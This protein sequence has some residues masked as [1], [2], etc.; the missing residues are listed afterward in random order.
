MK[1]QGLAA[2]STLFAVAAPLSA[3]VTASTPAPDEILLALRAGEAAVQNLTPSTAGSTV[4]IDVVLDGTA[5]TIELMPHSI[6]SAQFQLLVQGEDGAI[7]PAE[8]TVSSTYRGTILGVPDS[9]VGAS[10]LDAQVHALV[11]SGSTVFGIQPADELMDSAPHALHV[12][13][14]ADT[15]V[16]EEGNCISLEN[17]EPFI[18]TETTR[19]LAGGGFFDLAQHGCDADVQYFQDNGSS[20]AQTEDRVE[21]LVNNAQAIYEDDV[22]IQFEISA[23]II[24]SAEPDP[25]TTSSASGLLDQLQNEWLGPQSGIQHDLAHLFTGRNLSGGT[26]GIAYLNAVCSSFR[27]GLTETNFSPSITSQTGVFAH[28][29]GHNFGSNH[30][31]GT[32]GCQIMCANLGACGSITSFGS[33]ATNAI[34]SAVNSFCCLSNGDPIGGSTPPTVGLIL[35]GT[36]ASVIPGNDQTVSVT[37]IGFSTAS[38]ITVDGNPLPG[39]PPTFTIVNDGLI[40]LQMPLLGSLGAAPIAV[41]N[42]LGSDSGSINVVAANPP[43]IDLGSGGDPEQLFGFA[44]TVITA[45]GEPGNLVYL[46]ASASNL[47]SVIPGVLNLSIGNSFSSFFI[48]ST[49]VQLGQGWLERSF[50]FS[51]FPFGTLFYFQVAEVDPVTIDITTSNVATGSWVF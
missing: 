18:Q 49:D 35:P 43:A 45:G 8:P 1:L 34:T 9:R 27:Y 16:V 13:Y 14:D 50:N 10:I 6:R 31:I 42:P 38:S 3:Q 26:I 2:A 30:C 4:Q 37:G 40:T 33:F 5:Q 19:G 32:S 29:M 24:R 25:Y 11:R 39:F 36:V 22:Q 20:I 41:T 7:T 23:I 47:P 21:L 15:I 44:P 48:L 46:I 12:V 28:E 51:G 17:P